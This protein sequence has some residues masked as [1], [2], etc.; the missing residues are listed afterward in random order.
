[1]LSLRAAQ[2]P[3]HGIAEPGKLLEVLE[4]IFGFHSP[5]RAGM[6]GSNVMGPCRWESGVMWRVRRLL[7]T[8]MSRLVFSRKDPWGGRC[9]IDGECG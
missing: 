9:W 4:G 8:I 1:M 6:G 7:R 3:T 5:S 2:G